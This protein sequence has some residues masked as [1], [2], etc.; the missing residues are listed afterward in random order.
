MTGIAL[1]GWD[2]TGWGGRARWPITGCGCAIGARRSRSWCSRSPISRCR[3]GCCR[4]WLHWPA[5]GASPCDRRL[6]DR[7]AGCS[8]PTRALLV[9][10]LAMRVVFTGRSYGWRE[11]LWS[12][13]R[14]LVG[15]LVALIA[16][17]RA[18][19]ALYRACCAA[20][21]RSG[22]R[23]AHDFP[24]LP[25]DDVV[26]VNDRA[27]PRHDERRAPAALPGAGAGRMGAGPRGVAVAGGR[28]AS[29]ART[30][31]RAR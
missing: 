28:V 11:A 19:I 18:V 17:P 21:R 8:S 5:G 1:A 7:A 10:R 23:R 15:N 13:P 20:R 30:L 27:S 3:P 6:P 31:I 24:D 29:T 4:C 22:T 14:M 25:P 12:L 26:A 16:A 9:W 2:R